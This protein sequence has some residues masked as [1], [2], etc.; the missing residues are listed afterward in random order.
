MAWTLK[1]W[2]IL[3]AIAW[4]LSW[5]FAISSP[6]EAR[7][8]DDVMVGAYRCAAIAD[9]QQWLDCYYG[10]AQ[11]ARAALG[12]PSAPPHQLAL[13]SSPPAGGQP[14]DVP[15]RDQVI[16]GATG[17]YSLTADRAWLDCYY[18]AAQ[19]LRARLGLTPAPQGSSQ[20]MMMPPPPQ[21][22]AAGRSRTVSARMTAYSLDHNGIFTVTLDN[23]QVWHQ[24]SG[25][26][27]FAHWNKP[28]PAYRVTIS[29]GLLGSYNMRVPGT[30]H[31][32]KVELVR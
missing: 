18:G 30:G 26:T 27:T 2:Q 23:G 22:F 13:M 20:A 17:C 9:S 3:A 32:F 7:A 28:A 14:S 19:P 31:S 8:R 6:V 5:L 10:A 16:A 21:T 25:D 24:L 29:P 11:P 4:A 15:L 1:E 12:L